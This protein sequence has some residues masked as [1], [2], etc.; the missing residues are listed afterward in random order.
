MAA[1]DYRAQGWPGQITSCLKMQSKEAWSESLEQRACL[2]CTA[3]ASV[4]SAAKE[5][6]SSSVS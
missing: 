4:S 3:P 5:I 6:E 2:A 1:W